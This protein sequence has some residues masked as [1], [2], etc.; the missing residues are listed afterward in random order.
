M[1]TY[2]Q[3]TERGTISIEV[4]NKAAEAVV[5]EDQKIKIVTRKFYICITRLCQ[6]L[7]SKTTSW[8]RDLS[9]LQESEI[10]F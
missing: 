10:S 4:M 2:K 9:R 5:K 1:R 6:D 7:L 3:K 8:I